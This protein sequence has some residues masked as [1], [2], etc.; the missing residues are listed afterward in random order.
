[1]ENVSQTIWFVMAVIPSLFVLMAGL[2]VL[3]MGDE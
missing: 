1:M 2:F 3:T